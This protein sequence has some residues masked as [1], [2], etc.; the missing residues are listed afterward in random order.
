ML[1]FYLH[2][3]KFNHVTPQYVTVLYKYIFHFRIYIKCI[4]YE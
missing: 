3:N 4:A 2:V 1:V